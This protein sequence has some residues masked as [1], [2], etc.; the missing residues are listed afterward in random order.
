MNYDIRPIE[1]TYAGSLFRSRL[2]ARWAAMFDLLGWRWDYEPIDFSGW[3]PDFAIYGA[4]VVYA[5]VKPVVEFPGEVADKMDASGCKNDML[6]LGQTC[7]VLQMP[8]HY[9]PHPMLG[10]LAEQQDTDS[11]WDNAAFGRWKKCGGRIGFCH[12]SGVFSD[13]VSGEY[14]GGSW[15]S[16]GEVTHEEI[17]ILWR[18]AGA[19]VRW[20]AGTT[21]RT[22]DR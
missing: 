13:R 7:P 20:K 6:I 17:S 21:R 16:G 5:E 18:K 10:W 1:T 15:G 8:G 19:S 22:H 12:S 11:G 4:Y 14:D 3:I 2:E 9:S